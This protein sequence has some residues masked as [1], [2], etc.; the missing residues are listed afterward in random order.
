MHLSPHALR[1]WC[2]A[3]SAVLAAV[4][5]YTGAIALQP[6]PEPPVS[7]SNP[8]TIPADRSDPNWRQRF[9]SLNAR[10]AQGHE[11]GDVGMIFIGDS[12]TQGWEGPGKEAWGRFYA[13]RN[14]IN[15]G[16]SGDRTQHV[17]WRIDHGNLDGLSKPE[18]K[19]SKPPRLAVV[20]IGTNNLGDDTAEQI[21]EGVKS[22]VQRLREKLPD[23]K[24]L[25]LGIFP[26]SEKPG[27]VRDK[28]K[29]INTL[30]ADAAD[31]T[32]V[33]YLDISGAFLSPDGLI[34]AD[35][36]PDFLHLSPEGYRLWAEAME[37]KVKELLGETK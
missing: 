37:P 7:P 28:I 3:S 8:A 6:K 31:G 16:I 17:L 23:T 21:A 19:D 27:P 30:I 10:A 18:P 24:V 36:M 1:R 33:F 9:E 26:R 29:A 25:L 14:A 2:P 4:L 15:L 35:I 13:A 22:V 20:M 32:T 34:S 12:I 11:K 5:A